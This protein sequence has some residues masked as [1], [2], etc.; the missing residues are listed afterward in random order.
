MPHKNWLQDEDSSD[1][2]PG[3]NFILLVTVLATILRF[4]RLDGQS[5]WVD[6]I[7]TWN[8]IRPRED[9][10]LWTQVWD[11]IQAPLYLLFV[12]PLMRI[13][14]TEF[15][16]RLPSAV[17]GVLT[18]PVFATLLSRLVDVRAA[19]L[20]TLLLAVSP[21]HVWYSQ[22]GRGYSFLVFFV[23][24]LSLIFLEMMTK[25]P[26]GLLAFAFAL[27]GAAAI[28][29]NMSALFLIFAM[30]VSLLILNRPQGSKEWVLWALALAGAVLLASPWILKASGIWAI[31]RIVPG[32]DTGVSLRGESTFSPMAIP[33]SFFTFFFG[34]SF[35]PSLRELHQPD[36]LA[37]LRAYLPWLVL[38]AIPV[39]LGLLSSLRHL[40]SKRLFLL[41]FVSVPLAILVLL[42]VRNIKP[43]NPRY[44]SVIF[45]FLVLLLALGVTRLPGSWSRGISILMIVLSFWAL[46]GH[47]WNAR[48]SK[49]DVRQAVSFVQSGNVKEDPI[50]VPVVTGVYR[51]Y[52]NSTTE[53]VSTYGEGI[54]NSDS[55]T[56]E[57]FDRK[58][59]Q[60]DSFWLVSS[61]EWFFDPKGLLPVLLSRSGNL[62][63]EEDLPGVKIYH[64]TAP[65]T[66]R[67]RP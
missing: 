67:G 49:A 31:D 16:M 37:V 9:I 6:E 21:F 20:G 43:W 2:H 4:Y 35:G 23:V 25:G 48:Y 46:S 14:E 47:Y 32:A 5:L 30:G 11:S 26:K 28:L 40:G 24:L 7:L 33:Y 18:I 64:W 59:S 50:L 52:D 1:A 34:Y 12:W 27:T 57:F 8:M 65:K 53:L 17:A 15:M 54:L 42:A 58:L 66:Q 44:L 19:R 29:S 55:Q 63:L 38:G 51:F 13:S 3:W 22:E 39:F 10:H 36:R 60:F 56:Q 61:R 45:P 62:T 41:V